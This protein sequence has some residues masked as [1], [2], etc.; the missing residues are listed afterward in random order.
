MAKQPKNQPAQEEAPDFLQEFVTDA[1]R[2]AEELSGTQRYMPPYIRVRDTKDEKGRPAPVVEIVNPDVRD[3]NNQSKVTQVPEL[4][5]VILEH[6]M[7][8][9]MRYKDATGA[10]VTESFSVGPKKSAVAIG[11]LHN[12][13]ANA[14][15]VEQQFPDGWTRDVIDFGSDKVTRKQVKM[16][17]RYFVT[18]ALPE[19]FHEAAGGPI[20]MLFLPMTSVYGVLIKEDK[21]AADR[22][23]TLLSFPDRKDPEAHKGVLLQLQSRHWETGERY[24]LDADSTPH[25]AVWI[26][27]GGEWLGDSRTPVPAFEIGEELTMEELRWVHSIRADGKAMMQNVIAQN[28]YDAY[29][30][31]AEQVRARLAEATTAGRWDEVAD[32]ARAALPQHVTAIVEDPDDEAPSGGDERFDPEKEFPPEEQLPF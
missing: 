6:V 24:N 29:P 15:E 23:K 19:E 13:V 14:M 12:G 17:S 21:D 2:A 5:I 27:L 11:R 32:T 31:V 20:A 16:E 9:A 4:P 8:R 10:M 25:T 28:V 26:T 1:Q 30:T 3:E 7:T 18:V 22:S